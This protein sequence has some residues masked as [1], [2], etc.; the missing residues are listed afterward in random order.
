MPRSLK[1]G[2]FI[3]LHLQQKVPRRRRT[4]TRR[5]SRPGRAAAPSPPTRWSPFRPQRAQV[6]A[7]V[8][9]GEHGGPQVRRVRADPHLPR[10]PGDRKG[11]AAP[12]KAPVRSN[13]RVAGRRSS[14]APA[15][16]HSARCVPPFPDP[17]RPARRRRA[18]RRGEAVEACSSNPAGGTGASPRAAQPRRVRARQRPSASSLKRSVSPR[19]DHPARGIEVDERSDK[20]NRGALPRRHAAD[21]GAA[22][23]A[24]ARSPRPAGGPSPRPRRAQAPAPRGARRRRRRAR[25]RP[26]TPSAT[27]RDGCIPRRP[28]GGINGCAPDAPRA[29]RRGVR[30]RGALHDA[31]DFLPRLRRP[32]RPSPWAA[33]T[34]RRGGPARRESCNVP[35]GGI[36]VDFTGSGARLHG[37]NRSA[38]SSG[39]RRGDGDVRLSRCATTSRVGSAS[40]A[41]VGA[42]G[43]PGLLARA[44]T[45]RPRRSRAPWSAPGAGSDH[46]PTPMSPARYPVPA[47]EH[48][49]EEEV[50]QAGSSRRWRAPRRSTRRARWSIGCAAMPDATHHCWA[51][52]PAAGLHRGGGDE[53]RRRAPRHRGARC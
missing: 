12:G 23:L 11:K 17:A 47:A 26:S 13:A 37:A 33:A 15:A 35:A 45:R 20:G 43:P 28:G 1:K 36:C 29:S 38:P 8:R 22:H 14:C 6:R 4:R 5:S 46:H 41:R 27:D 42:G 10:P 39:S 48:R 16:S 24:R 18:R 50:L 44:S 3:D 25:S 40:A 7:R 9:D 21:E 53:R 19:A 49:V 31:N 2:P 51:R 30:R 52:W 32:H 34:R